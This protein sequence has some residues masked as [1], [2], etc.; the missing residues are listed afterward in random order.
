MKNAW[1]VAK[2]EI[3]VNMRKKSFVVSTLITVVA[4]LAIPFVAKYFI[5]KSQEDAALTTIGVEESFAEIEPALVAIGQTTDTTY[6]VQVIPASEADQA[7]LDGDVEA[8]IGGELGSSTEI[9]FKEA[10]GNMQLQQTLVGAVQ[11]YALGMEITNLGGNPAE[12][13][14]NVGASAPEVTF[15][16][17]NAG[18]GTDWGKL[19]ASWVIIG[20][21]FMGIVMAGSMISMGVVEEKASRVVEI[22]LATVKP[23]ELFGGK[24]LGLGI[25]ALSQIIIYLAAALGGAWASGLLEGLSVPIGPS[26]L[27]MLL[28]FIIGFGTFVVI[29]GG[30]SALAS[31]QED[32]G[33]IT[34]PIMMFLFV[35]FYTAMYLP[36][37]APNSL[38]TKVLSITPITSPFVMP[39]RQVFVDVPLWQIALALVLGVATVFGLVWLAG[40]IY[41]RGVLHTG[42]SLT[43]KQAFRREA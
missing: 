36:T 11:S 38:W 5:D 6:E 21:L 7:L 35:P 14:A 31:R 28:W 12:V 2:R 42:S 32:V 1:L 37:N 22:L 8:W 43:L 30:A 23:M 29:W 25:V 10:P 39:V 15:A 33:N 16:G 41:L 34:G 20:L 26:I 17:D 24:V 3:F 9:R 4:L 18:V 19:I 13:M 27:W 40:R